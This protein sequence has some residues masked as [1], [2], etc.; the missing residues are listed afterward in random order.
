M[1][2]YLFALLCC[3]G[4]AVTLAWSQGMDEGSQL[5]TVV[6]F[7]RAAANA[8][9]MENEDNYNMQMRLGNVL[10]KCRASGSASTFVDWSPGKQFPARLSGNILQVKGPNGQIVDWNIV[11]KK[12]GK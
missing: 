3:I 4:V 8:Q 9:H 10:Y 2:K 11:G 1:K 7:E 6:T 12:V 5:G